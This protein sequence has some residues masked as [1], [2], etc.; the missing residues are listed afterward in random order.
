MKQQYEITIDA[1]LE[2]VWAAFDNADN[3]ARWQQNFERYTH[4]SG[5]PGEPGAT[6]E[7]VYDENGRKVV[8]TETITERR[9][10]DFLASTYEADHGTT[11]IVNHFEAVDDNT[12]RWT[13]WCN[14]TFR[15]MMK[16]MSILV[17]GT[18]R[19]RTEG[20][21]ARFKLMVESDKASRGS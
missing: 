19:K 4:R 21:M 18:I 11:I 9:K 3:M 12:T 15:G 2:D 17:G 16:F 5:E 14:F 6:A 7:L 10:P 1:S 13:C 20:D 8:L